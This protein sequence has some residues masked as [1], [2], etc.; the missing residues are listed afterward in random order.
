MSR[1]VYAVRSVLRV[2][3]EEA[4]R[5]TDFLG[6]RVELIRARPQRGGAQ[7]AP[8]LRG[9]RVRRIRHHSE[10]AHRALKRLP[11]YLDSHVSPRRWPAPGFP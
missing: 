4:Q 1:A 3:V 2:A 5:V 9:G 6:G 10:R 8:L 7:E 11:A